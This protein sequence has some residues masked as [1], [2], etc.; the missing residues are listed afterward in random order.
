MEAATQRNGPWH[1]AGEEEKGTYG[2]RSNITVPNLIISKAGAGKVQKSWLQERLQKTAL[3]I[4]SA[5][6][7]VNSAWKG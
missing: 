5:T 6:R 4:P 7:P 3:P 2:P 1:I